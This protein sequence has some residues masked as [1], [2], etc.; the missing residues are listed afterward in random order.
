M[1]G[2]NAFTYLDEFREKATLGVSDRRSSPFVSDPEILRR[3]NNA[4]KFICTRYSQVIRTDS[5]GPALVSGNSEYLMPLDRVGTHI[6]KVGVVKTDN[7]ILW[8]RNISDKQAMGIKGFDFTADSYMTPGEPEFYSISTDSI[9]YV[10]IYP[11]P[12]WNKANGLRF[13]M[14]T[15][16]PMLNRG[17]FR[18]TYGCD[19]TRDSD[20]VGIYGI[21]SL[22]DVRVGDEFGVCASKN[23]D[24]TDLEYDGPIVWYRVLA[25]TS[26][27]AL[28]DELFTNPG[29][30]GDASSWTLHANF[31]YGS[32]DIDFTG[33]DAMT[34][35]AE[36]AA[37][38]ETNRTY[39]F[40]ASWQKN[41]YAAGTLA[42]SLNGTVIHTFGEDSGLAAGAN[43]E[44]F[45]YENT[46]YSGSVTV[47][48]LYTP[49]GG[50]PGFAI[51]LDALSVKEVGSTLTLDRD[52]D[53]LTAED[54]NWVSAQVPDIE[55]A[56]P[57]GLRFIPV[58]LALADFL[59]R[60]SPQMAAQFRADAL[61]ELALFMPHE[62]DSRG[63]DSGLDEFMSSFHSE[64]YGGFS[65]G[66]D[67]GSGSLT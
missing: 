62:P 5:D 2:Y 50:D 67:P 51:S 15:S 16:G 29:F 36:Q 47:R 17:V 61:A 41:G 7:S 34:G 49:Q 28:R 24:G 48:F 30:T 25:V 66:R 22:L 10:K 21:S 1:F 38:L 3:I 11:P 8:L 12:N 52:Y 53:E 27:T 39:R 57:E 4:I 55:K 23:F 40:S 45:D 32:N 65:S 44:T 60:R 43:T 18:S 59:Q 37:A 46:A 31:S 20:S 42:V 19:V 56:V 14:A 58:H 26:A 64:D 35:Y 9:N 63:W 33:T 6:E 54:V 13:I